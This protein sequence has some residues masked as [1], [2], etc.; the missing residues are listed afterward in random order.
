MMILTVTEDELI[1]KYNAEEKSSFKCFQFEKWNKDFLL[2]WKITLFIIFIVGSVFITL[3]K[4][5]S[6]ELLN[7]KIQLNYLHIF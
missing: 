7:P 1:E 4:I 3:G 5:I 6:N 2:K